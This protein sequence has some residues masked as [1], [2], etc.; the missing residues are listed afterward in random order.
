MH[1]ILT[2]IIPILASLI[3][4]VGVIIIVYGC[5]KALSMFAK[6]GFDLNISKPKLEL[7]KALAF[8]LEFKLA[9]EILKTVVIQTIDEF[10]VLAAIVVLRVVLTLVIHWEIKSSETDE[11]ERKR[12]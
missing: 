9:A 3:E 11:G 12:S 4:S 8:S 2:I 1:A 10:I 6:D 5:I 7:A